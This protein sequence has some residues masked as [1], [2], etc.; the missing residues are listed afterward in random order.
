MKNDYAK[1]IKQVAWSLLITTF[2]LTIAGFDLLPAWVGYIMVYKAL[3][4][5][6]RY[7]PT[8]KLLKPFAM[9]LIIDSIIFWFLKPMGI[10]GGIYVI[11]LIAAVIYI[12]LHFQ[13]LTDIY[14][15]VEQFNMDSGGLIPVLRNITTVTYA[16]VFV[17]SNV[18]GNIYVMYAAGIVNIVMK[19]ALSLHLFDHG[20]NALETDMTI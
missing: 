16:I 6:S 13:L 7:Q 4:P 20:N 5:I 1:A 8:A 11:N 14:H 15:T 18:G 2:H 17:T 10:T 9:V 19:V 12:Y 3:E